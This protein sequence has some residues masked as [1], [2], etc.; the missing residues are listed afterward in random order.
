V[1]FPGPG[2][3]DPMSENP[4]FEFVGASSYSHSDQR[5]RASAEFESFSRIHGKKYKDDVELTHRM[6]IF[7]H[8][9]RYI[10]SVNRRNLSY[11]LAVNH[12]ADYSDKEFRMLRGVIKTKDSPRHN[13]YVPS[14]KDVPSSW[15]WR[16]RGAVTPVKDQG[17]CGSCWSFGTTG[18]LEGSYFIKHGNLV[19]LS[20]Q[21]LVDCSWGYGNNGCDGGESERSY[22]W[23][24]KNGCIPT[25]FTYGQ[26]LMQDGLCHV[27]QAVC[28]VR[29]SNWYNTPQGDVQAL[30]QAVY[31]H[32]P[33]SIAIDASH[34]SFSFYSHGVYFEPQCGNT[35]DDLDHQVLAVG[36]GSLDGTPYI[37]VKNSWS[38]HWGN[39]GY[40]LMSQKDN[41]CGIATDASYA[42]VV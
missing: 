15:N 6:A 36:Y 26:Y 8:N 27:D 33:I 20:E 28:G 7:N 25:E 22:K 12:M 21:S 4:F 18:T 32:G 24:M 38:T 19:S 2:I 10:T 1:G 42:D 40:I 9:L 23:I 17:I 3:E 5:K 34:L 31:E 14:N 11:K 39:A 37:L 41:N 16:L 13:V 29:I 35:P 30:V